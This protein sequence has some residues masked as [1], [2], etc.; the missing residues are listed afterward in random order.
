MNNKAPSCAS[1]SVDGG[2]LV[3]ENTIFHNNEAENDT[4]GICASS[5]LSGSSIH[6]VRFTG[7]R[8]NANTSIKL[9][10]S[11]IDISRT[12]FQENSA[13][14]G[15]TAVI[16]T[17]HGNHHLTNNLFLRN[18]AAGGATILNAIN[19]ST[20]N[21]QHNTVNGDYYLDELIRIW[22]SSSVSFYYNILTNS[23]YAFSASGGTLSAAH[24][25]FFNITENVNDNSGNTISITNTYTDDPGFASTSSYLIDPTSPAEGKASGS[26][27]AIDYESAYRPL[28]T[29]ADLG[30]IEAPLP[31]DVDT[32]SD[33]SAIFSDPTGL[34]TTVFVPAGA[35]PANL[36]LF[37]TPR[38]EPG[39]G[40]T[41]TIQYAG[42]A[43][44]FTP[45][46]SYDLQYIFLPAIMHGAGL[47]RSGSAPVRPPVQPLSYAFD[48]PVTFT[49]EYQEEDLGGQAEDDLHLY[50]YDEDLDQ[51]LDAAGTCSPL[52]AYT[53]EPE[54]DRFSVRVCHL[55]RFG[56]GG[57]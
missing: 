47:A 46:F 49:I 31:M 10:D 12:L 42:R 53:Y 50:Y 6:K 11:T 13:L 9:V 19:T 41:D 15:T 17:D 21:M 16:Y 48:L 2:V 43:F 56:I 22:S 18:Y 39:E 51:W 14:N 27:T 36:T 4:A 37:F 45:S 20:V 52:S 57:K 28:G 33:T 38:Q 35:T 24:N 54:A 32:G 23:N 29:G 7:N 5:T 34:A 40:F 25:I 26:T 55:S 30:A 8:A 1:L 44:E 3:I